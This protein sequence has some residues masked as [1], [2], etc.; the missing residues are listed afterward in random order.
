[1]SFTSA[2]PSGSSQDRRYHCAL[3]VTLRRRGEDLHLLTS[4]VTFTDAF[5]RTTAPPPI[6]SLV[7]LSFAMPPDE[8][9]LALS[10]HVTGI[11]AADSGVDH[12][13]GF[14][15]RFVGLDGPPR[16][17]WESLVWKLRREHQEAG[18]STVVFARP[19]YVARFQLGAPVAEDLC[20]VPDTVEDLARVVHE[21][22]PSGNLFVPTATSMMLGANVRVNVVHPITKDVV[23]LDGVVRRRGTGDRPGVLVGL[24][25]VSRELGVALQEL[26]ESV[27][28]L[29]D[30]DIELFD[31]PSVSP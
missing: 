28:V 7:R 4:S 1:M 10:A 8:R 21:D 11:V 29:E 31:D 19:S 25:K 18:T 23:P 6:N 12:Y 14:A 16:E 30:Y 13:P 24:A 17:L 15:A 22:V 26:L 2:P 9:R 5:I 3:P 27:L 20:L